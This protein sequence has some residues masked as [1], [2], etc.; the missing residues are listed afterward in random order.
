M[1]KNTLIERLG[2][3]FEKLIES[4]KHNENAQQCDARK[5]AFYALKE[6]GFPTQKEEEWKYVQ[7]KEFLDDELYV[8]TNREG[9]KLPCDQIRSQIT[10]AGENVI[11]FV[12]GFYSEELS[13]Y[14]GGCVDVEEV[15]FQVAPVTSAD[16]AFSLLQKAF[17]TTEV[18]IV[19]ES[20][21]EEHPVQILFFTYAHGPILVQ[22][23]LSIENRK[24]NEA[25]I[26]EKHIH[27]SEKKSLTNLGISINLG[28]F[29]SVKHYRMQYFSNNT[30]H[31][32]NL[33][34]G[35]KKHS[36]YE[37]VTMTQGNP[38]VRNS[39]AIYLEEEYASAKLFGAYAL[40]NGFVDNHTS[41]THAAAHTQ[42]EQLYKGTL[43]NK[44][45][46]VFNG[47]ILVKK[48]LTDIASQQSNK[49][50][51]LSP[52]ARMDTKPELQIYSDD[53]RCSHGAAL[54]YLDE[55]ALFFMRARGIGSQKAKYLL[56]NGFIDEILLKIKDMEIQKTLY[57]SMREKFLLDE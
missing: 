22:P 10:A 56:S 11:V 9:V 17:V 55:D 1:I 46:G 28:M 33:S 3:Q 18:K 26:I 31:I 32:H 13:T 43:D 35:C 38:M 47:K 21:M 42:S 15:D 29:S 34:I 25:T 16:D 23:R 6:R 37:A 53:V 27:L 41:I 40:E 30:S 50:I 51:V 20:T 49:T 36:S 39:H 52:S 8:C 48:E 5:A 14:C 45:H 19:L 12:N 2:L 57:S 44:S 7:I 4:R 54:G 24:E